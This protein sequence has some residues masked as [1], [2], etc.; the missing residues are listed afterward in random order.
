MV[1][2]LL[3]LALLH[4]TAVFTS[5]DGTAVCCCLA[6]YS[7]GCMHTIMVCRVA[8]V[9]Q[10]HNMRGCIAVCMGAVSM[11]GAAGANE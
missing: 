4:G 1:L 8:A 5:D 10:A 3:L 11:A 7:R 2:L 9:V 6:R